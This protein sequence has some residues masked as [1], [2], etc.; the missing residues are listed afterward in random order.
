MI[1]IRYTEY[2]LLRVKAPATHNDSAPNHTTTYILLSTNEYTQ[3]IKILD[4]P[5]LT[6]SMLTSNFTYFQV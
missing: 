1:F 3:K 2:N 6:A 5:R 4:F